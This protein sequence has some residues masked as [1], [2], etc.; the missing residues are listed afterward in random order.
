M[1]HSWRKL[2][3]FSKLDLK[4]DLKLLKLTQQQKGWVLVR[5]LLLLFC[6]Q[7]WLECPSRGLGDKYP[8]KDAHGVL[9]ETALHTSLD[10]Q[11]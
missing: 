9:P 5:L 4:P 11:Q 3:N 6:L 10:Q 7:T 1:S 8:S 2:L